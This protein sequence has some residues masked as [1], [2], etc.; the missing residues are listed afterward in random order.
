MRGSGRSRKG[1]EQGQWKV[2][3]RRG[4]WQWGGRGKAGRRSGRSR[5]GR[6]KEVEERQGEGV[7]RSRSGREKEWKVEERQGEGK[8]RAISTSNGLPR[9]RWIMVAN[10]NSVKA[11]NSAVVDSRAWG[12]GGVNTSPTTPS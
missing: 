7:G 3:E 6:E 1:S 11:A 12:A 10:A 8:K 5:K 2:E 4:N 9:V